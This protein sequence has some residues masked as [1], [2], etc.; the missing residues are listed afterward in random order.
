MGAI[1]R[2]IFATHTRTR[3]AHALLPHKISPAHPRHRAGANLR[4]GRGAHPYIR[5]FL[6]TG[7]DKQFVPL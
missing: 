5:T 3:M 6:S 2:D 4:R 7:F 1:P